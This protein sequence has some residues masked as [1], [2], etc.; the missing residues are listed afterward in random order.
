MKKR[1]FLAFILTACVFG[2]FISPSFSAAETSGFSS[3]SPGCSI[4]FDP[5]HILK[6]EGTT[7]WW[8]TEN[9]EWAS[10]DSDIGGV[11]LEGYN[12]IYPEQS[13][14]YTLT[15]GG[16]NGEIVNCNAQ[17]EVVDNATDLSCTIGFDP[18]KVSKGEGTTLWWWTENAEWA[19]IDNGIGE[20]GLPQGSEWIT[21][22]MSATYTL[23]IGREND[24]PH[25][26]T[27]QLEVIEEEQ[28]LAQQVANDVKNR[29]S[30][31]DSKENIDAADV[32]IITLADS[33]MLA[34]SVSKVPIENSP[35]NWKNSYGL[36]SLY[37]LENG[38]LVFISELLSRQWGA[39]SSHKLLS[40]SKQ[41]NSI[42]LEMHY[43]NYRGISKNTQY[44]V[45][46]SKIVN[47]RAFTKEELEPRYRFNDQSTSALE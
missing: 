3:D 42:D 26:C 44:R 32:K 39:R 30:H 24:T 36:L 34:F 20:A 40:A 22:E 19:N 46:L 25:T 43:S 14:P 4:G 41:N 45:D 37:R 13:A 9:A 28:G 1:L 17:I 23:S 35:N 10:I 7:L 47:G 33:D 12:W 15:V 11:N 21:P 31:I 16:K 27:V 18:V 2:A 6:G 29:Y 38:Q 8:W 5:D